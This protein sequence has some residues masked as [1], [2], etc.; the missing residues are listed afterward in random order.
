[1]LSTALNYISLRL[2]GEKLDDDKESAVAMGHK[3]II[4]HGGAVNVQTWGKI[5]LS[6]LQFFIPLSVLTEFFYSVLFDCFVHNSTYFNWTG[7]VYTN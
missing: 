4:D 3:W 7:L 1:M 2:L 6:V 5:Y